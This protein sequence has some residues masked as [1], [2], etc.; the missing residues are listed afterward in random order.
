MIDYCIFI[1]TLTGGAMLGEKQRVEPMFYHVR[2]ADI[3]PE[4]H[5]LRL[6]DRYVDLAFIRGKVKHLYSPTGRPSIDPEIL[7]RMLL[8]QS[9]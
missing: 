1:N 3:I 6:V 8:I 7:L 5:L 2:M 9:P 4:N